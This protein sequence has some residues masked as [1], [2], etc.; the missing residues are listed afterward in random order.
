MSKAKGPKARKEAAPATTQMLPLWVLALLSALLYA[1]SLTNGLTNWDDPEYVTHN[2]IAALGWRGVFAAFLQVYDGCYYPL[3]HA[4]YAVVRALGGS[5]GMLHTVQ[6]I[7]MALTVAMVPLALRAFGVSTA[8]GVCAALLWAVHPLRVESVSWA[9]NLKDTL[10]AAFV[11]AAFAL[12]G[13]GRRHLALLAFVAA[14]LSKSAFFGLSL[15]FPLLERR[16]GLTWRAALA[17]SWP[18]LLAG[19]AT[20]IGSGTLHMSG[21]GATATSSVAERVATALW[22][23]WW[24]L[25]RIVFPLAPRAVYD[26]PLVGL[27][28]ARLYVALGAWALLAAVVMRARG[29]IVPVLA[30]GVALAP[31][32]GVVPLAFTVA[33][34]YTLFPSL[35]VFAGVSA[36]VVERWG[37][38]AAT[39]IFGALMVAMVPL[40]VMRQREWHDAVALWEP[41]ARQAS[42]PVVSMNLAQAYADAGRFDDARRATEALLQHRH[43]SAVLAQL[44]WLSG[45]VDR[46]PPEELEPRRDALRASAFS[47]DVVLREG[48]WFL[49]RN[50]LVTAD[51]V[52]RH[53]EAAKKSGRAQRML[54]AA[55]RRRRQPL[56]ALECARAAIALGEP[57]ARIELI[58]ALADT[59]RAEE[60]LREAEL[61]LPDALSAALLRGA[62]GYALVKVGRVEEGRVENEAAIE[63]IRRLAA[64]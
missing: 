30:F 10:A 64:P 24:Y 28:D 61:P 7:L 63:E 19:L 20:A 52:L 36:W 50:F 62:R 17:R 39:V 3:T 51:A 6:W 58:Y 56:E 13:G 37:A 29:L 26:F 9:A 5:A 34:R 49:A 14:M 8:A 15:L 38:R 18:F 25:G 35:A 23:P 40:N 4:A 47:E 31:V 2:P 27:S 45:V 42:A 53:P 41:N 44:V 32:S 57:R 22:T 46:V 16:T 48:E 12:L 60:A 55:T 54:S 59:G 33:D 43:D 11:V 21:V 1:P